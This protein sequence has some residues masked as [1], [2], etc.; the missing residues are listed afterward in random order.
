[1]KTSEGEYFDEN[2]IVEFRYDLTKTGSH[3]WKWTPMRIRHDKT[4]S[5][6]E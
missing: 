1:M 5:L 2:M 4:Q 3:H 6:L